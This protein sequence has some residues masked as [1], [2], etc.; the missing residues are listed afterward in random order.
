MRNKLFVVIALLSLA[1]LTVNCSDFLTGG[2]LDTDPNQVSQVDYLSQFVAIQPMTYGFYEADMGIIAS[3]WMQ[4]MSGPR[5]QYTIYEVY[6]MTS[7]LFNGSW[8]QMY[9]EGGLIDMKEVIE[10]AEADGKRFVAGITKMHQALMFATGA[11]VWGAIPYSEAAHPDFTDPKYDSQLE[12]HTNVI[13]LIDAA[14]ADFGAGSMQAST[15]FDFAFDGDAAKWIAVAHTLKARI[16]LNWGE[17]KPENYA[18]ALAEAQQGIS[19]TAGSWQAYHSDA[20]GEEN[21]YWQFRAKR[22]TG[23]I[24]APRYMVDLLKAEN[25]PRLAYYY[26]LDFDG[27]YTGNAPGEG[28]EDA[29]QLNPNT[30]AAK[31]AN[32]DMVTWEENQFI[33]AEAQQNAGQNAAALATLNAILAGIESRFGFADNSIKRYAGLT[34]TALLQAIITEKHKALFLNPQ[35]W[36]DWKRTGFPILPAPVSYPDRKIPHRYLYP[37]SEQNANKNFPGV[38]GLLARN[39]NDPGDPSYLSN[40]PK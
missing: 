22:F 33:I 5:H 38:R 26:E 11:D 30:I 29:S 39:Q 21:Y 6:D 36:S 16:I 19:S 25:D 15:S 35:T 7:D 8:A 12:V 37:D 32:F 40:L 9:Q 13:S 1:G 20:L 17:V 18:A 34:G 14:I 28:N 23:Y 2:I 24:R 3:V 31:D 27:V 4:H 10:K